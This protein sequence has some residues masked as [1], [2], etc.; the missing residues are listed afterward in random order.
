MRYRLYQVNDDDL[1]GVAFQPYDA[2]RKVCAAH[3]H[4]AYEG[5]TIA[6]ATDHATLEALFE[7]FNLAQPADFKGYALSLADV[8][9]LGG[10]RIYY[11]DA[12][13]WQTLDATAI[14]GTFS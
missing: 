2:A 10:S 7:K 13:G 12:V 4:L 11:C 8:V 3:Y 1:H 6:Q 9:V 14:E 5:Q